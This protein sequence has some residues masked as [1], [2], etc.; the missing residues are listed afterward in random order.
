MVSELRYC[1]SE[2]SFG[3]LALKTQTIAHGPHLVL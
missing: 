3:I 1:D 2:Q